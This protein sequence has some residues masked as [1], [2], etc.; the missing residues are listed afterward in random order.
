VPAQRSRRALAKL[1][2]GPIPGTPVIGAYTYT[3]VRAAKHDEASLGL[4]QP[5]PAAAR[6]FLV[7]A[8]AVEVLIECGQS[9]GCRIARIQPVDERSGRR[10]GVARALVRASMMRASRLTRLPGLGASGE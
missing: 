1:I 9:P 5:S 4:A 10:V 3:V 6:V 7:G 8:L 2:D